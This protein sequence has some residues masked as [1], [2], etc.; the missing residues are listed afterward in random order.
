M[1]F[2]SCRPQNFFN[3]SRTPTLE[4]SPHAHTERR[5]HTCVYTYSLCP[6]SFPFATSVFS[7]SLF[8]LFSGFFSLH[9][10]IYYR[11]ARGRCARHA[12]L[13][14]PVGFIFGHVAIIVVIR[15]LLRRHFHFGRSDLSLQVRDSC[16]TSPTIYMFR[17]HSTRFL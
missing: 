7:L 12:R 17:T 16:D 3:G 15:V 4:K 2:L 11:V 9:G 5:P 10:V 13:S 6:L 14:N 1:P 8:V